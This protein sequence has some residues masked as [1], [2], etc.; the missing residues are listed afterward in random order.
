MTRRL[1]AAAAIGFVVVGLFGTW[2]YAHNYLRYRGFPPPRDPRNVGPGR[3]VHLHF[4]SAALGS[5]RS[6]LVY[7]PPDYAVAAARGRRY[8]VLYLLHGSP[9]T[10]QLYFDAGALGVDLDTMIA[11]HRI[12][13]MI[14]VL[15]NGSDGTL[16]SDTEWANTTHGRYESFVLDTV[17]AAD[18]RFATI[19]DRAGRAIAGTSEGAY[20]AVNIGLRHLGTFATIESWS[21][22]FTQT[23][24][25]VFAHA[26]AAQRRAASPARYVGSLA[27]RLH[28]L[29]THV[30]LYGGAQ[31]HDT[32]QLAPFA[33]RLRAAG[34][35]VTARV[36]P[37]RHD[38]G[39]WRRETPAALRYL[40]AHLASA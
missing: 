17:R 32:R 38:W 2:S 28:A 33:A 21:G 37:G 27:P 3:V 18:R 22:Y 1:L 40:D 12:R 23:H 30:L 14:V 7:L 16:R 13:P 4:F 8:P 11:R 36:L 31:D 26:T 35:D 25:G 39:F 19:P 6:A 29:P 10:P 24:S 20:A 5:R 34:G 9:G 15:P